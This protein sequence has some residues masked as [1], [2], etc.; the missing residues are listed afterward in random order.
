MY[1]TF[2]KYCK[3]RNIYFNCR[4]IKKGELIA[5]LGE[6]GS[7]KTC[8]INAILNYIVCFNFNSL[9]LISD[10]IMI[11]SGIF[12]SNYYLSAGRNLNRLDDISR[13]P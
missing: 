8:L 13:P 6:A 1:T 9:S 7:G 12:I 5:I 4:K 3:Y 10:L 11:I 2:F